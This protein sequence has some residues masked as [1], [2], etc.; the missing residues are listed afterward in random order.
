MCDCYVAPCLICLY[1]YCVLC[2]V[3]N[4]SSHIV[5]LNF[6]L[7]KISNFII[8][9]DFNLYKSTEKSRQTSMWFCLIL[10]PSFSLVGECLTAAVQVFNSLILDIFV[11]FLTMHNLDIVKNIRCVPT[12]FFP[13]INILKR[14]ETVLSA[15]TKLLEK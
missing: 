1:W 5:Q 6:F 11:S 8:L 13:W 2:Q 9:L 4:F 15:M 12:L 10:S 3:L 14:K 7:L